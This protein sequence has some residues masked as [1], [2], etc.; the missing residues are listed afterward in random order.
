VAV[1]ISRAARVAEG[2]DCQ[3]YDSSSRERRSA[4]TPRWG[5]CRYA[6]SSSILDHHELTEL[7]LDG[8]VCGGGPM[9]LGF[10]PMRA[11][12][13][14]E[15]GDSQAVDVFVRCED[16]FEALEGAIK[17]E[18]DWA[19]TLSVVPIELDERDVSPN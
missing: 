9:A 17:D 5:V 18:P 19:G 7:L 2:G 14:V 6:G 13:L 4:R 10:G 1:P 3:T 12:V 15:I 16:A 11:Y 8:C